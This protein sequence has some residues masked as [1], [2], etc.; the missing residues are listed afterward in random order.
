MT[1]FNFFSTERVLTKSLKFW[2]A[3]VVLSTE[4]R[5]TALLCG[6]SEVEEVLAVHLW[7]QDPFNLFCLPLG[8]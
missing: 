2:L 1:I 8:R 6:W 3:V 4:L 7:V 5:R